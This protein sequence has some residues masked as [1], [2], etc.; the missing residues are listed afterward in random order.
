MACVVDRTEQRGSPN[1]SRRR[2]MA[3]GSP[4]TRRTAPSASARSSSTVQVAKICPRSFCADQGRKSSASTRPRWKNATIASRSLATSLS[5]FALITTQPGYFA[6]NAAS[7]PPRSPS[8]QQCDR[9]APPVREEI[10]IFIREEADKAEKC[11]RVVN[12]PSPADEDRG[13]GT[14]SGNAGQRLRQ[15]EEHGPESTDV[16]AGAAHQQQASANQQQ[17]ERNEQGPRVREEGIELRQ[18]HVGRKSMSRRDGETTHDHLHHARDERRRSGIACTRAAVK[19][20][21]HAFRDDRRQSRE[22][23]RDADEKHPQ[24]NVLFGGGPSAL[25]DRKNA[26]DEHTVFDEGK[27]VE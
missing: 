12:L 2:P 27:K 4:R 11:L 15:D 14:Q 5:L 24:R 10:R 25:R 19:A 23:K 1:C 26:G 9:C 17:P 21:T 3:S 8:A 7:S 6:R 20:K 13:A 22:Q 16:P 18:P